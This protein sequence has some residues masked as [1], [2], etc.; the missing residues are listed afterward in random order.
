MHSVV[1][2]V[3]QSYDVFEYHSQHGAVLGERNVTSGL[4]AIKPN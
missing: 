2:G 3:P 4:L 1:V